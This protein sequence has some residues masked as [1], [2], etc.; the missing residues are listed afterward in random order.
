MT[1]QNLPAKCPC[2]KKFTVNH[3][4]NCHRGG[5]VDAR[6]NSIRNFEAHMLKK[7][8]SDVQIEPPLQPV[9]GMTFRPS[10]NV[11][12]EA[13]LDYRARGFW[14]ERQ[15]GFFDVK[16]TNAEA[17]FQRHRSVKSILQ[18]CEQAKK[19]AYNVRVMEIEQGTFT[20]IILTVKGVMGPEANR[21]HKTLASKIAEKTGERYDD[22]TRIIRVKISFL[23]L[24]AALLCLRGSR[25]LF[26]RKG[27]ECD[28]DFALN[29][30]E[31]GLR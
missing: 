3:A 27:E 25:T 15:D 10:V 29:V 8:C 11:S 12:N 1:P 17:D 26:S 24:R 4:M 21:Y 14:R 6:H 22:V 30:N 13:R 7:V 31:L 2:E 28:D 18:S 5:F 9:V 23:V 20:P 19:T 16:F